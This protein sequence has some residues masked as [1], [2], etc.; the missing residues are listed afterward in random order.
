MRTKHGLLCAM[1]IG[2]LQLGIAASAGAKTIDWVGTMTLDLGV[3]GEFIGTGGGVATVNNSSG[4]THLN[5]LRLSDGITAGGTVPV[6]DPETTLTIQSVR[7]TSAALGAGTFGNISGGGPI[8]PN[9]LPVSG[10]AKVCLFFSGCTTFLPLSLSQG[11]STG[12]GVGGLLTL[13]GAGPI[14]IS[15]EAGGWQL[16][17]STKITQTNNGAFL[18]KTSR[19]FVHGPASNTSSTAANSGVLQVISPM[20][21]FTSGVPGNSEKIA[22]FASIRVHFVPEPGLLLLIGSGVVGLAVIGRARMR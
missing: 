20:Q 14:R 11:P 19:G 6:T 17:T 1:A 12:L 16:E 15:V 10:L 5:T 13:G 4:G 7:V 22:L 18:P 2:V 9:T 3:L 21:V 8:N